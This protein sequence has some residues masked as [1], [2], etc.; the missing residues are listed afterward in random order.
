MFYVFASSLIK[1][2]FQ[3]NVLPLDQ[4]DC[5]R[6]LLLYLRLLLFYLNLGLLIVYAELCGGGRG[7]CVLLEEII[8]LTSL[9]QILFDLLCDLFIEALLQ[10]LKFYLG[11]S[12]P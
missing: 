4:V 8:E 1:V 9:G 7:H 3:Y 2:V 6:W 5:L 11:Q 12:G 10:I